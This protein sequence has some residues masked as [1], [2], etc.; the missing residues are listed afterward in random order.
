[1]GI[2][3]RLEPKF[4]IYY[5]Y[6]MAYSEN[7][8]QF[9]PN[10]LIYLQNYIV[11]HSQRHHLSLCFVQDYA[12]ICASSHANFYSWNQKLADSLTLSLPLLRDVFD[13]AIHPTIQAIF[14]KLLL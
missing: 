10:A 11:H 3:K 8:T 7:H 1:M 5:Q 2:Y 6:Q 13:A 4:C 14:Q 12:T 9:P